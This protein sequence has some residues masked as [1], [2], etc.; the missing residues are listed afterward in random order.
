MKLYG[1]ILASLKKESCHIHRIVV[2]EKFQNRGIASLLINSLIAN[3]RNQN[4]NSIS[5]KVDK[6]TTTGILLVYLNKGLS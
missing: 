3:A 6:E 2:S 1:F 5:L 4:I